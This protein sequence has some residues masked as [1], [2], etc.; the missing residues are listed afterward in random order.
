MLQ[1]KNVRFFTLLVVLASFAASLG[2]N[3]AWLRNFGW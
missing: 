2:G 1:W 3:F